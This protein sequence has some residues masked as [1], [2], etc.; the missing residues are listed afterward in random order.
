MDDY[1]LNPDDGKVFWDRYVAFPNG[2]IFNLH[3]RRITGG[4]NRD[5]Y[6][7]GIIGG[8]NVQFHRIIADLFCEHYPG[9]DFVNH[10]DGDKTNNAAWNLEWV[11]RSENALHAFR[12]GL[13]DNIAGSSIY[14]EEEKNIMRERRFENY[15]VVASLIGRNPAT[16]RKYLEKYRKE[17]GYD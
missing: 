14:T 8:K 7:S 13:Q 5:G 17:F 9:C 15:R 3:G 4:Q 6:I 2:M 1:E 10:I 12:T 11:T 16:V